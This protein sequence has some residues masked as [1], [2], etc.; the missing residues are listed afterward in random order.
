MIDLEKE[1]LIFRI[2]NE[3]ETFNMFEAMKYPMED[4]KQCLKIDYTDSYVT[5]V[6][7]KYNPKLP[8]EFVLCNSIEL[9]HDEKDESVSEIKRY[10]KQLEVL[11]CYRL[12]EKIRLKF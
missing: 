1:D 9:N 3:N 11:P 7:H 10:T 6:F 5:E 8:L 12:I 4:N 2:N